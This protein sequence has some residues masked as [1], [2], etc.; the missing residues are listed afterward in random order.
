MSGTASG[1]TTFVLGRYQDGNLE[2]RTFEDGQ[3]YDLD[4]SLIQAYTA[5]DATFPYPA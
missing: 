1:V 5:N 3:A 4:A 2:T